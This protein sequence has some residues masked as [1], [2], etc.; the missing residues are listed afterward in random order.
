VQVAG[1]RCLDAGASTGG[2]TDVLLRR[3]VREVAAVDLGYG[4]P[5]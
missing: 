5:V 3:G 1:R 2:F 4:Q